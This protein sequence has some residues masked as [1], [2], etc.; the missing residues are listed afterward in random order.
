VSERQI[1][2]MP[3]ETENPIPNQV[4]TLELM[5]QAHLNS[6]NNQQAAF[7]DI[8]L[9]ITKLVSER[10]VAVL[11]PL[12]AT[13]GGFVLWQEVLPHP[14][15]YQLIGLGLYGFLIQIPLLWRKK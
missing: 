5:L 8:I 15:A 13:I 14:D 1:P 9:S 10:L 7:L 11:L 6:I 12:L 4:Q 2:E 3:D